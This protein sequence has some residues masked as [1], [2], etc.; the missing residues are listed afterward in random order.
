MRITV[1]SRTLPTAI[2]AD[3]ITVPRNRHAIDGRD[4]DHSATVRNARAA[5]NRRVVPTRCEIRPTK[6]EVTANMS[7]GN[8]FSTPPADAVNPVSRSIDGSSVPTLVSVARKLAATKRIAIRR[9]AAMAAMT[10][11]PVVT[12]RPGSM[13]MSG[14]FERV[15]SAVP[16]RFR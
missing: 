14:G 11:F 13:W 2:A 6:G 1:G 9:P 8:V 16:F 12:A 15:T 10:G 7:S 4:R 5:T 3:R